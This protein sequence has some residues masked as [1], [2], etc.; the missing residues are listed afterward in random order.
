VEQLRARRVEEPWTA[1]YHCALAVARDGVTVRMAHG[2][3]EGEIVAEPRGRGGFGYDPLFWLPKLGKTMAEMD[4]ETKQRLSHR[5]RAL[6]A[7][8]E[9]TRSVR[10]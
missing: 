3:V 9:T 7:L 4:L 8:L 5:G 1:L 6:Q 2:S 10:L